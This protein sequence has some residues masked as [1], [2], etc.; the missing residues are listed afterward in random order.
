[1]KAGA[2]GINAHIAQG[3]TTTCRLLTIKR[4]ADSQLF[5]F[6]NHD[7]DLTFTPSGSELAA[8]TQIN[9]L[10]TTAFNPFNQVDK[11][12]AQAS[13]SELTG[14]FDSIITRADVLAGLW[15]E[16]Q[17]Q[18]LLVNWAN[19]SNGAII[20]LTGSFGDFEPQEFGFRTSLHGLEYPLTFVGGEIC[21]ANC[22]VDFGS[23]KCA[24]GGLLADGTD[25]NTLIQNLTVTATD[26]SRSITVSGL[27]NTGKN[28]VKAV[29]TGSS[30]SN[31]HLSAQVL[32]IDFGTNTI[33][34]RPWIQ[35]AQIQVGD[36]FKFFP[37][38]DQIFSTCVD[39]W[40]NG[41][42]FQGEPHVPNPDAVLEYPDYVAPHT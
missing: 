34:L 8:G 12:S 22:R 23:A 26:G 42:N 13:D 6:T 36:T 39:T 41:E 35:V 27:T 37:G 15:D 29:V 4:K 18:I 28:F 2:T 20:L 38:C 21:Q 19:L 40:N 9:Y 25:I 24:P 33:T 11:I 1:M 31:N 32:A 5:G 30:G 3:Q 14:G 17:F 16:S 10:S 7:L